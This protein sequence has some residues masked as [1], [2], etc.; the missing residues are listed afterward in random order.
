MQTGSSGENIQNPLC[1]VLIICGVMNLLSTICKG[2]KKCCRSFF[3]NGDMHFLCVFFFNLFFTILVLSGNQNFNPE[4]FNMLA[5][6][7]NNKLFEVCQ[8][9]EAKYMQYIVINSFVL[10]FIL[11]Q[12]FCQLASGTATKSMNTCCIHQFSSGCASSCKTNEIMIML[13]GL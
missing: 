5:K 3:L 11:L 7:E 8:R 6:L 9:E 1:A 12:S 2:G 10:T 13:N 4:L